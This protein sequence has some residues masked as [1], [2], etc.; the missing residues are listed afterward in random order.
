MVA[1]EGSEV[2]AQ[3]AR[4]ISV[5]VI[6]EGLCPFAKQAWIEERVR[7]RVV[8]ASEFEALLTALAGELEWIEGKTAQELETSLL[9]MPQGPADFEA[10]LDLVDLA[11]GLLEAQGLAE[12]YQ[13]V[14]FHP[15]YCFEDCTPD[16]RA[17]ATNRSPYPTLQLLRQASVNAVLQEHP[18]PSEIYK[19]NIAHLRMMEPKRW[20]MLQ[21]TTDEEDGIE[22]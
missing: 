18:D 6:D 15:A 10:F 20:A 7:L 14:A 21:G 16:D 2:M 3:T 1:P 4:W 13:L 8:H 17:N 9:I 5:W 19:R 12:D 11:N 22:E